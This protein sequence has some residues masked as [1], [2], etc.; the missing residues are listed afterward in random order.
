MRVYRERKRAIWNSVIRQ[1]GR[2]KSFDVYNLHFPSKVVCEVCSGKISFHSEWSDTGYESRGCVNGCWRHET[3]GLTD[4]LETANFSYYG[5]LSETVLDGFYRQIAVNAR[6]V[7]EFRRSFW[8]KK[9][10][11]RKR[12]AN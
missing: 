11:Q 4:K 10:S 9:M 5:K 7:K 1:Q 6:K 12:L 3:Y 8:L 2:R